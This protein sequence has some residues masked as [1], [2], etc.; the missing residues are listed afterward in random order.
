MG[1]SAAALA[2]AAV[3]AA[4]AIQQGQAAKKQADYQAAVQ[5][6]QAQ[7]ELEIAASQEQD[8]RRDQS[9]LM[10][11]RR[12]ALGAS[13]IDFS[14]G[15]P[16]LA[17]LDFVGEGELQSLRIRSGGQANASRL[18]QQAELT[19]AKGK[20][21]RTASFFKAGSTLLDG[22]SKYYAAK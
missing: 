7:R 11:Q 19:R 8:F 16:L 9:R 1:F 22:A 10:A 5:N 6:Q 4:G 21:A 3:S 18:K 15:S 17:S 13:G 12:A 14:T 2:A 20:S